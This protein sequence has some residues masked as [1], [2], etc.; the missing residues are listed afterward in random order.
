M[1][2]FQDSETKF[3]DL[4]LFPDLKKTYEHLKLFHEVKPTYED[5]IKGVKQLAVLMRNPNKL[6][7]GCQWPNIAL[8]SLGKTS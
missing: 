4:A 5:M 2:L 7:D 3:E 8:E 6:Q 1:E